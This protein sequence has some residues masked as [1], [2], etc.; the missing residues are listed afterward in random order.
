MRRLLYQL[1]SIENEAEHY[2]R[3]FY[4][5]RNTI[6]QSS[7]IPKNCQTG[8]FPSPAEDAQDCDEFWKYTN[9]SD[10]KYVSRASTT[11]PLT[12]REH[13]SSASYLR[14]QQKSILF[15]EKDASVFEL[16]SS[17]R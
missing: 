17:I 13:T 8:P 4:S 3:N 12:T 6:L 2:Y 1:P 16:M 11:I 15:L 7:E 5:I 9:Q 14:D 10:E